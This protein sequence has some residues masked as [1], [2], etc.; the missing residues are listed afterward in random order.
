[1]ANEKKYPYIEERTFYI[2]T[3]CADGKIRSIPKVL[4][5]YLPNTDF[6]RTGISPVINKGEPIRYTPTDQEA[7][8][9]L[10]RETGSSIIP[11]GQE[12]RYLTKEYRN[13][14]FN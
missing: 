2:P 7:R 1:M 6:Y 5:A 13:K 4:R 11:E 10:I 14:L 12:F 9:K 8:R 3:L